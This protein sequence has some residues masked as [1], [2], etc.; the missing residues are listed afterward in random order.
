MLKSKIIK[1][2]KNIDQSVLR[3]SSRGLGSSASF[4]SGGLV[5]ASVLHNNILSEAEIYRLACGIEGP[6]RLSK[7]RGTGA[8]RTMACLSED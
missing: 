2:K 3:G 5:A 7:G 4:I 6:L 1:I 8:S